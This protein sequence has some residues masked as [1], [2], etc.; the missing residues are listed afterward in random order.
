MHIMTLSGIMRVFGTGDMRASTYVVSLSPVRTIG[1][2]CTDVRDAGRSLTEYIV[3]E[4]TSA[5][6]GPLIT[7]C[8]DG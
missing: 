3:T 8:I 2:V 5:V 4:S 7:H 6:I 1:I